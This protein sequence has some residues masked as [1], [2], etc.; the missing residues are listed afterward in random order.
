MKELWHD[1]KMIKKLIFATAVL[2]WF[3]AF[4]WPRY[5]TPFAYVHWKDRLR[6]SP[7][8][9]ALF[10]RPCQ[11]YV[12][13]VY[14]G[15]RTP[16]CISYDPPREF[17]GIWIYEFENSTFF[18]NAIEVP[19]KRPPLETSVWLD[20]DPAKIFPEIEF[21][22]IDIEKDCFKIFAFEINFIGR[23]T[24]YNKGRLGFSTSEILVENVLSI[25]PLPTPDCRIYRTDFIEKMKIYFESHRQA[26]EPIDTEPPE[27][28]LPTKD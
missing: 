18:E 10:G 27:N 25:K 2:M 15:D 1:E 26:D 23:N 8:I 6:T 20:Y 21:V 24:P 19:M 4:F 13:G 12:D 17:K 7:P 22:E 28:Q 16:N 9:A 5:D 3:V 14:S 11:T